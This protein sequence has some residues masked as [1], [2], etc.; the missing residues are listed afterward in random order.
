MSHPHPDPLPSRR[1]DMWV[2]GHPVSDNRFPLPTVG[3]GQGEG[4]SKQRND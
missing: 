1:G 2:H 3:E 4:K